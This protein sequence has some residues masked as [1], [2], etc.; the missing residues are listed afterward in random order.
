MS[1]QNRKPGLIW[2]DEFRQRGLGWYDAINAHRVCEAL[3]RAARQECTFFGTRNKKG[4]LKIVAENCCRMSYPSYSTE[5]LPHW[6]AVSDAICK[7]DDIERV[8]ICRVSMPTGFFRDKIIPAIQLNSNRHEF[9]GNVKSLELSNCNLSNDDITALSG[10][11]SG[12]ETLQDL[13]LSG[14]KIE[15]VDR[16]RASKLLALAI[17]KHPSL[18]RVNLVDVNLDGN[19][20][21][22]VALLNACSR[23]EAFAIGHKDTDS[24]GMNHIIKFL[25]G[26]SLIEFALENAMCDDE[27]IAKLKEVIGRNNQLQKLHL[28]SDNLD[29]MCSIF[30]G[31]MANNLKTLTRLELSKN[32]YVPKLTDDWGARWRT[33]CRWERLADISKQGVGN[34]VSFLQN[35]NL[36]TLVLRHV[37]MNSHGAKCLAHAL[38]ENTALQHLDLSDN[39][40]TQAAIPSFTEML[41]TNSSLLTLDLTQNNIKLVARQSLIK[42]ALF[43]TTTLQAIAESN[44]SCS[45]RLCAPK[46]SR[47]DDH[48]IK[49]INAIDKK[50]GQKIR[51]KVVLALFGSNKEL[52]NCRNFDDV[53]LELMPRLL[54]L[55]QQEIGYHGFGK[56][57]VVYEMKRRSR[58]VVDPTLQRVYEVVQ[59]WNAP[60]LFSR[61]A[62]EL[63]GPGRKSKKSAKSKR[64]R[65]PKRKLLLGDD[66]SDSDDDDVEF[67]PA[68]GRKGRY[69]SWREHPSRRMS[70]R[71]K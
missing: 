31:K 13:N 26:S 44:H 33:Y 19:T 53:P 23:L 59:G 42:S 20:N 7:M 10:F 36:T 64:Q 35:H 70:S 29:N 38:K 16:S 14:N 22:L 60:L 3:F 48:I 63:P 40:I 58:G 18:R 39:R 9:Y 57:D 62:G 65:K 46:D 66:D 28:Y 47:V 32:E 56:G 45:V 37:G 1:D 21:A 27:H 71:N 43:D 69:Y 61:G 51:Y 5:L 34:L 17:K 52:F 49:R 8:Q 50:Q 6:N 2:P 25:A 55:V 4:E 15:N 54:E 12:N 30:D 11:L 67:V 68:G 24:K 41:V